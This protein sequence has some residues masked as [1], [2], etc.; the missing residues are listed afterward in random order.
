MFS[1]DDF[2]LSAAVVS[3]THFRFGT[4]QWK[5]T[6]NTNSNCPIGRD[7]TFTNHFCLEEVTSNYTGSYDVNCIHQVWIIVSCN[8]R[9]N[10]RI[11]R[12]FSIVS[13]CRAQT[14]P[15]Q[16]VICKYGFF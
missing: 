7:V 16:A 15:T 6:P 12:W 9:P 1:E 4:I 5:Q 11:E 14:D 8:C 3:A 13:G 10:N 2:P